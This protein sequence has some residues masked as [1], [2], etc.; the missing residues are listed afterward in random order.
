MRRKVRGLRTI[1]QAVLKHQ[2]ALVEGNPI[3]GKLSEGHLNP[4]QF[5]WSQVEVDGIALNR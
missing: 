1:E 2:R 5:V 4:C 3:R